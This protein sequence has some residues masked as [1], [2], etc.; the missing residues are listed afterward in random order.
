MLLIFQIDIVKI[1]DSYKVPLFFN[2]TKGIK[3]NIRGNIMSK[4]NKEKTYYLRVNPIH[5]KLIND[6]IAS[7]KYKTASE[8]INYLLTIAA[9]KGL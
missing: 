6:N 7:G 5:E 9:I 8:Y 3:C 4:D 1:G 2:N